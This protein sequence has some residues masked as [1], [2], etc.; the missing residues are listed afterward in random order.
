MTGRTYH[1][2]TLKRRADFVRLNRRGKRAA[3]PGLVLQAARS[4][5]PDSEP[6]DNGSDPVIRVGFTATK[7][8]GG[9]VVRNRVKRRLRAVASDVLPVLAKPGHDFV[10]IGRPASLTRAYTDLHDDL[11]RALDKLGARSDQAAS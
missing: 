9:A 4:I 6:A 3:M 11:V 2:K 8:L 5:S 1:L 7:K 10:L